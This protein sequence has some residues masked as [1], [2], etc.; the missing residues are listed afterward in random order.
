MTLDEFPARVRQGL[1]RKQVAL[2]LDQVKK[3]ARRRVAGMV[4]ATED[5]AKHP[6]GKLRVLCEEYDLPLLIHGDSEGVG[7]QTGQP[8]TKV[9]VLKKNFAGLNQVLADLA[10]HLVQG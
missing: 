3:L 9:Y 8:S 2:G 10:E 4:W 7:A 5:L 6:K 1:A